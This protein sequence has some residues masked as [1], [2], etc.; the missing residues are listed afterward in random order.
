[1]KKDKIIKNTCGAISLML[2]LL[3]VPFYAVAGILVEASRYQS[4]LTGFDDAINTSALSVLADYDTFLQSRFGLLAMSQNDDPSVDNGYTGNKS[5]EEA[6]R[7]YLK[8]Q[9]T[10]DTRSFRTTSATAAGVYPLADTD[11][12]KAQIQDYSTLTIPTMLASEFGSTGLQGVI[13]EVQNSI[14]GLKFLKVGGSIADTAT[15]TLDVTKKLE[16]AKDSVKSL[17]EKT[18]S[19]DA[20]HSAF[21]NALNELKKTMEEKPGENATLDELDEYGKRYEQALENAQKAKKEYEKKLQAEIKSTESL[22]KDLKDVAKTQ[23]EVLDGWVNVGKDAVNAIGDAKNTKVDTS[24]KETTVTTLSGQI[25]ETKKALKK[26][27]ITAEEKT[28]LE[29]QLKQLQKQEADLKTVSNAANATVNAADSSQANKILK[30]YNTDSCGTAISGLTE[31][32]NRVKDMDL[33]D[34]TLNDAD[35]IT[36]LQEG[37]HL[38]DMSKLSDSDNFN[39]LLKE[40]NNLIDKA[41]SNVTNFASIAEALSTIMS[42]SAS[43]DPKLQSVINTD[44][45]NENFGGLPGQKDRSNSA[46]SLESPYEQQDSALAQADLDAIDFVNEIMDMTAWQGGV[47]TAASNDTSKA[48]DA[49]TKVGKLLNSMKSM[50]NM[51][52]AGANIL[53]NLSNLTADIGDHLYLV[54]YLNYTTTNRTDYASK[55]TMSGVGIKGLNGLANEVAHSENNLTA[56]LNAKEETNYSFCGAETEY[57]LIGNMHEKKNQEAIFYT[58][59]ALR[60]ALDYKPVTSN[61]EAMALSAGLAGALSLLGIPYKMTEV[62]AK[63]FLVAAEAYVDTVLICNGAQDI[64]FVKASE[65]IH[66][67][68]KGLSNLPGKLQKLV[69]MTDEEKKTL[70]EKV[71]KV[72]AGGTILGGL[73]SDGKGVEGMADLKGSNGLYV[74]ENKLCMTYSRSLLVMTMIWNEKDLVR[75]FADLIEMETTQKNLVNNASVSQKLSGVYPKFDLDKAYTAL[76]MNVKGNFVSVLPVPSLSRNSIWKTN[77][78]MYRGY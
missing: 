11:I 10:T 62:L 60:V 64:P 6:F 13:K 25:S 57:L 56:R 17:N 48:N 52:T 61:V 63:T 73:Q 58:M 53:S 18:D 67:C 46:Y 24:G 21:D 36:K 54:G 9:D 16:K 19:Y 69:A 20:A 32:L 43:F 50:L 59:L 49:K 40:A 14:P 5:L 2:A 72:E 31:E 66:F 70:Q 29:D 38:T 33:S 51:V 65:D 68:A 76:R 55:K 4:A 12:L 27:G 42:L 7:K 45:Y 1:M 71:K 34:L 22:N 41:D 44:Y 39:T 28:K 26:E 30:D 37:L 8:A 47:S 23:D 77:R 15:K 75:R 35:K 3:I 74:G 78:I